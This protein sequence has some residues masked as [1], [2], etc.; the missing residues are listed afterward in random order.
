MIKKI[1]SVV[2]VFAFALVLSG[3]GNTKLKDGKEVAFK[4]KGKNFT[5][6]E[7]YTKIKEK[8]GVSIMIDMID[9]QIYDKKFK[10]LHFCG[11]HMNAR[12]YKFT[13]DMVA[14]YIDYYIRKY[15]DDF[16]QVAFI[17]KGIHNEGVKW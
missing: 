2:L 3:C 1:M 7:L 5:A 14:T 9:K 15:P 4:L 12:G 6:D 10:R 17:G 11:T 13:A 8:S 16:N